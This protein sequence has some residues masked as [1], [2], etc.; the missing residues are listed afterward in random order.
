MAPFDVKFPRGT[1]FTFWSLTF[2]VGE[3]GDKK[4]LPLEA[5]LELLVLV[6]GSDPCSPAE[7]STSD[8][9]CSGSDP[10]AGLFLRTIK[11]VQGIYV[12]M[13]IL[14]PPAGASSSSSSA[15]SPRHESFDDYPE[16]AGST[17]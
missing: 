12:V 5:A 10:C 13:S 17:C 8:D 1:D 2:T 15:T 16:I 7:S 4:M 14:Q 11:I 3:D 6:H 9:T